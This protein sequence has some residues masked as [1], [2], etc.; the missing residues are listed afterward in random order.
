MNGL[1][2]S[3]ALARSASAFAIATILALPGAA[4]AQAAAPAA[5]AAAPVDTSDEV[6]VTGIRASLERSIAI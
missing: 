2:L 6:V 3:P 4:Y 1:R 5:A